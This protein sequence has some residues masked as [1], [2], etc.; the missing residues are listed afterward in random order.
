MVLNLVWRLVIRTTWR[1]LEEH[2]LQLLSSV[3]LLLFFFSFL[4]CVLCVCVCVSVVFFKIFFMWTKGFIEFVT[5]LILF[6]VL[7]VWAWGMW[8]LSSLNR[9]WTCSPYIGRQS[10]N[11]GT[12]R[13]VPPIF[14]IA[15]SFKIY[16]T[17]FKSPLSSFLYFS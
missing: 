11:H 5:I 15:K 1:T 10:L 3:L 14:S 9:D 4:F 12:A 17:C 6:Y 16:L 2:V 13:E 7:V 8:D